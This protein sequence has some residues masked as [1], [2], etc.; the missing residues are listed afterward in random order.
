MRGNI[1]KVSKR[2]IGIVAATAIIAVSAR[3][4]S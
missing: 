2:T 4:R 3:F 1:V